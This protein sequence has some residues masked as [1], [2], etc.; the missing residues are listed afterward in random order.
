MPPA[1]A[2]MVEE[3][4]DLF[5][6][7]GRARSA[8]LARNELGYLAAHAG[9]TD[10]HEAAAREVLAEA[11]AAGDSFGQLQALCSWSSPCS[12]RVVH[13][14]EDGHGARPGR[15]AHRTG[16]GT[17]SATCSA[18]RRCAS[19]VYGRRPE[20]EERLAGGTRREPVVPRHAAP[21]PRDHGPVAA[22]SAAS[23]F[24]CRTVTIRPLR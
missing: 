16:S 2:A 19:M 4:R 5:E 22:G 11:E 8:P 15:R 13:E 20:A 23:W 6:V 14:S 3:A 18:S 7:G 10:A 12:G 9:D 21:G 1:R 17:G 24:C